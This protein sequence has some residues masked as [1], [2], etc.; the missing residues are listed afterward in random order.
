MST[1]SKIVAR[2]ILDS[3]GNP[4][5]TAKVTL[6]NGVSGEASVP[7]GA[8]TG[9]HEAVELRDNDPKRYGGKGV[10]TAVKN[11]NGPIAK[12]LMGKKITSLQDIDDTMLALDGTKN[13]AKLGANAILAV[14]LAAA[15]AGAEFKKQP[16]YRFIRETYKL[17]YS[18][19][20]LPLLA[21]NILNGGVHANNGI[22]VQEFMVIPQNKKCTERVRIGAEV[23]QALKAVLKK[24]GFNT[25]VG[26]EGG[27]APNLLNNEAALKLIMDGIK[28]SGYTAGK[29]V[30]LAMDPA[31]SEWYDAKTGLY[32]V[33]K[34]E[35]PY[36]SAQVMAMLK[37]WKSKYPIISIEDG[38]AED[39]WENWQ[40]LTKTMGK[41]TLLVGDDLFVTNKERLQMGIDKKVGNAILIKLNQ[42]GSLSETIQTIRTAQLADYKIFMSHR[43]GETSDTTIADLAVAV[44][45]DLIKSGAP[46][47]SE[48]TSKYNRLMEIE[49]DLMY[50]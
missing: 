33:S 48:R 36:T 38:L 7:S 50:A 29:D 4:T 3:R 47:R 13:K 22:S 49:A 8:S 43:S 26:D 18:N 20:Q 14:S 23:Y 1:I 42:I 24:K 5:V 41:D 46:C 44:N 17:P 9:T 12:K 10:L 35:K 19:Y 40:I 25:G 45:A 16:L 34:K 15:H 39:D 21:F 11:V 28:A 6:A 37:K 27:F 2:E 31:S 32:K 30:M